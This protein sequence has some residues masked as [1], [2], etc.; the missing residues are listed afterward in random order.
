MCFCAER[1]AAGRA[2]VVVNQLTNN[3]VNFTAPAANV[4]DT[5]DTRTDIQ[6]RPMMPV[7]HD[8][9]R[10]TAAQL[11]AGKPEPSAMVVPV[12]SGAGDAGAQLSQPGS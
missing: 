6:N 7:S 11:I 2:P 4:F 5:T 10:S 9:G 3:P 12:N 1:G 8:G